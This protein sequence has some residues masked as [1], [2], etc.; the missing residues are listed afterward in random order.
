MWVSFFTRIVG[1]QLVVLLATAGA[2]LTVHDE[3]PGDWPAAAVAVLA[4]SIAGV[5]ASLA[6]VLV[7]SPGLERGPTHAEEG[8]RESLRILSAVLLAACVGAA[9]G[10]AFL[11]RT[12]WGWPVLLPVGAAWLLLVALLGTT[13]A[14][15]RFRLHGWPAV[16]ERRKRAAVRDARMTVEDY[17]TQ[18]RD[19]LGSFPEHLH[20][21]RILAAI[22]EDAEPVAAWGAARELIE[23]MR[24]VAERVARSRA[25]RE[26]HRRE[27]ERQIGEYQADILRLGRSPLDADVVAEEQAALQTRIAELRGRLELLDA[28]DPEGDEP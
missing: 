8:E 26:R 4:A 18:N 11:A 6:G 27:L 22:P 9:F 25:G 16:L 2:F 13:S 1:P 3:A 12:E 7:D 5:L 17:W 23:Q 14:R 28:R 10:G 15:E 21:S 19:V 20:H 24:Q